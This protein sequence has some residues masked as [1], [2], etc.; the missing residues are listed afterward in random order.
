MKFR[1]LLAVLIT[2]T[3]F[4]L[5]VVNKKSKAIPAFGRKYNI[6]CMVCHTPSVPKLKAFGDEFAGNGFKLEEYQAP[7]YFMET[8]DQKLSLIRDFPIAVRM[9]GYLQTYIDEEGVTDLS[10]PYLLKLLSGGQLSEHLAYY[11]YFYM[12]EHGEIAGVEDAYLMFNNLFNSELD[13]YV[14]QFQVSDPMFKRELRLTFEDYSLYT[15]KIGIS[16]MSMKYDR[17]LMFTYGLPTSTDI[18]FEIVNGN[19]LSEAN[20]L[21]LFDKDKYKSYLLRLSQDVGD[22]LRVGVVGYYG[23]EELINVNEMKLKNEAMFYGPDATLSMGDKLE[24]NMQYLMRTD[25]KVYP[26]F[27]SMAPLTDIS[28]QGILGELIYS[29]QGDQSNWYAVGLFNYVDSEFEPAD[30]HAFTAHVGYLLRRNVRLGLEYTNEFTDP[31]NLKNR[32]SLGFTS[33]F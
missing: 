32:I 19:G 20:G 12:N 11:F 18:M 27:E 7:R 21:D 1:L 29:P 17:G 16:E 31:D 23:N 8:G 5:S 33:A 22:F 26:I 6:S 28:T 3:I 4:A 25:S 30:Y 13:I 2:I 14:G 24:L 15:A 10:S 9:D